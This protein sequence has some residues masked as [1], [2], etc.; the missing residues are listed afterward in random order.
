MFRKVAIALFA[1]SVLTAPALAQNAPD[2]SKAAPTAPAPAAAPKPAKAEK[3]VTKH[4]VVVRHH[5]HHGV[6]AVHYAKHHKYVRHMKGSKAFA[7]VSGKPAAPK[8]VSAKPQARSGV[9]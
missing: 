6:K 8:Q 1:A 4:H 9:N 2:T 7:K 5:R 3:A